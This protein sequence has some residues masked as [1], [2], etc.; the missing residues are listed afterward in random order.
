LCNYRDQQYFANFHQKVL[1][2]TLTL[3]F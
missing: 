2:A 1:G 3:G